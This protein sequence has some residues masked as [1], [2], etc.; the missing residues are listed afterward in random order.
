M[1]FTRY[2]VVGPLSGRAPR[3]SENKVTNKPLVLHRAAPSLTL[4]Q[5]RHGG[6]LPAVKHKNIYGL[7]F[8]VVEG[9]FA[10]RPVDYK[11]VS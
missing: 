8:A 10:S 4:A 11:H 5:Q 9:Q 2:C 1:A 6:K 7:P 3:Q